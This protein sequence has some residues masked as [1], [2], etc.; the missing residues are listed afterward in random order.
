MFHP[1]DSRCQTPDTHVL[2]AYSGKH[3]HESGNE[4]TTF[5][6]LLAVDAELNCRTSSLAGSAMAPVE[7]DRRLGSV[8]VW[9]DLLRDLVRAPHRVLLQPGY[10]PVCVCV[11]F[12]LEILALAAIIWRVP[13]ELGEVTSIGRLARI[14]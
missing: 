11:V 8:S 7:Y 4:L 13:C 1:T 5:L 3:V 6:H 9:R 2:S 14:N 12:C 10:F